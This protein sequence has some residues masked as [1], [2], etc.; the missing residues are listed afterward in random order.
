MD[1]GLL[2]PHVG[3]TDPAALA[4][5]AEEWGY[6][7]VWT[8]ELWGR[9]SVVGL[10]EIAVR[11][12]DIGLGSAILNVFSRSP[13]VLAMTAA[14]LDD[15]SEGRFTLGVGTS[16]PKAVED[17][18]GM[19][20]ERPVRRAHECIELTKALLEGEEPTNYDG[21]LFHAADFPP[22]DVEV[23]V[24]HAA[25]G[26]AN[27]RVVGRLCEGWLP[28][29]V[30]FSDLGDAFEEVAE[31]AR[32]AE[33]DPEDIT[34]APYV[35]AVVAED[36]EEAR[37]AIRGHVAYYVGSGEGYKKAVASRFPEA[38]ERVASAWRAGDREE[39]TG[40]VT[41]E[42]VA[43]LGIAGRPDEAR[44]QLRE[45]VEASTI[46]RPLVVVPNQ[47]DETLGE[48]TVEALAPERL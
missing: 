29:N 25:L 46:D 19:A 28:H 1:L 2:L 14:T 10:T 13:A 35:P 33:R 47:V 34:V 30:P 22:L 31:A 11:T 27:R 21:E 24:Y 8:G 39:A 3:D 43:A 38:A 18:H 4:V 37:D 44:A 45:L 16:T 5:R 15:V 7:S 42:M 48:R 12:D 6:E 17:L 20:F 32:G 40:A 23:P 36:P 9:S 41:D 26:P